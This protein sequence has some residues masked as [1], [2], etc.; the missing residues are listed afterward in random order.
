MPRHQHTWTDEETNALRELFPLG[1]H[2]WLAEQLNER[3][4]LKLTKSAVVGRCFLIGLRKLSAED[5]ARC[6]AAGIPARKGKPEIKK[7]RKKVHNQKRTKPSRDGSDGK[8]LIEAFDLFSHTGH[9]GIS[10]Y[11]LEARHCR[12]PKGE[13]LSATY[14]GQPVIEGQ[15]YCQHCYSICYTRPMSPEERRN[16]A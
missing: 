4:G 15:S 8:K 6:K 14:C 9:L 12:F 3:F 2:R 13:G 7:R 5:Y 10:F 11:D 1:S 16:A